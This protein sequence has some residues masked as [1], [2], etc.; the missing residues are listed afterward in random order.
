MSPL[1]I[2]ELFTHFALLLGE[3]AVGEGPTG[4]ILSFTFF[5]I[6]DSSMVLLLHKT[7]SIIAL[8]SKVITLSKK[9]MSSCTNYS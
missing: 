3:E 7:L 2:L 8:E 6:S 9:A 1:R 4:A 5:R